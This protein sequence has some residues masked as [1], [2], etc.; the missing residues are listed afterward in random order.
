LAEEVN[1]GPADL[2]GLGDGKA[3]GAAKNLARELEVENRA[4]KKCV[5][6]SGSGVECID[7]NYI[8]E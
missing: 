5:N 3:G 1:P 4:L 7:G 6:F 2:R 8:F